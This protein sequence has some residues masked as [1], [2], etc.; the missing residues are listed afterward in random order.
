[1][2]AVTVDTIQKL[3]RTYRVG[4]GGAL[5][6]AHEGRRGNPVLFD[7]RYLSDLTDVNGD[8]GG[9]NVIPHGERSALVETGDPCVHWDVDT[10]DDLDN[11]AVGR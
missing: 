8:V 4:A 7:E 10:P 3:V 9:R 11:I 2:L 5:A 6:A 1:M